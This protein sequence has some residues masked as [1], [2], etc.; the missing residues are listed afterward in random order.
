MRPVPSSQR[1]PTDH[2]ESLTITVA[3][4]GRRILVLRVHGCLDASTG[5]PLAAVIEYEALCGQH[6]IGID[7][8]GLA[9]IDQAGMAILR[10]AHRQMLAHGGRL[11]VHGLHPSMFGTARAPQ[12]QQHQSERGRRSLR[13]LGGGTAAPLAT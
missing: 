10:D 6:R 9:G 4:R 3:K 7:L 12:P 11:D 8:S 1:R 13:L 5:G 2:S